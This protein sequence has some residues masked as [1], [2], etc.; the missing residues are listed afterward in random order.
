MGLAL[1]NNQFIHLVKEPARFFTVQIERGFYSPREGVWTP[2]RHAL[3]LY[4]P[5]D[6]FKKNM[7]YAF[8]ISVFF[9]G[10][11]RSEIQVAAEMS[12]SFDTLWNTCA[13]VGHYACSRAFSNNPTPFRLPIHTSD[14]SP[15]V[16]LS[17]LGLRWSGVCG[18][19]LSLHI[20]TVPFTVPRKAT[21]Q[22]RMKWVC[23]SKKVFLR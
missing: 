14:L 23:L 22:V 9:F 8:V 13:P 18:R 1:F 3:N 6:I 2:P 4:G 5:D 11:N 20:S 21:Q 17:V 7:L 10:Q 15:S 16:C 19:G 12:F